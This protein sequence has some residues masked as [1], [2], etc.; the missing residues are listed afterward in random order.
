MRLKQDQVDR[1]I[2]PLVKERLIDIKRRLPAIADQINCYL[3][4]VH[5]LCPND[6]GKNKP[7]TEGAWLRVWADEIRIRI[8]E[9]VEEAVEENKSD[10]EFYEED[11]KDVQRQLLRAYCLRLLHLAGKRTFLNW[12]NVLAIGLVG[13]TATVVAKKVIQ[14]EKAKD[15]YERHLAEERSDEKKK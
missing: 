8:R 3:D 12:K 5:E 10:P 15:A 6:L 14:G 2:K 1:I 13:A 4:L 9:I 7:T 11:L